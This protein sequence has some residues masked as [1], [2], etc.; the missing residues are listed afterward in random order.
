MVAMRECVFCGPYPA[1]HGDSI[2]VC[3]IC[4]L[5]AA[6]ARMTKDVCERGFA[7]C[8]ADEIRRGQSG[9]VGQEKKS[10]DGSVGSFTRAQARAIRGY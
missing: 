2:G 4:R 10:M 5:D 1:A 6:E 8:Y 7:A 9:R 3:P